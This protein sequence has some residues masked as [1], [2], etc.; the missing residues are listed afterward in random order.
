MAFAGSLLS[1]S[2]WVCLL[3][4]SSII[5]G[6]GIFV[7][8]DCTTK[9]S[10]FVSVSTSIEGRPTNYS[11]LFAAEAKLGTTGLAPLGLYPFLPLPFLLLSCLSLFWFAG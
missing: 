10:Y 8:L 2:A 1:S 3:F 7:G 6:V 4:G 11:L 9:I 5:I